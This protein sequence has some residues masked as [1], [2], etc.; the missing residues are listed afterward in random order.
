MSFD[1]NIMQDKINRLKEAYL[2]G[3]FSDA[4]FAAL[5][6]GNG[7][8]QQRI[9]NANLDIDGNGFG[10]YIGIK[11]KAVKF[12]STKNAL[13]LKRNKAILGQSLTSY[14]RYRASRGRQVTKKDLE[15]TGGLRRAIETVIL[16]EKSAVL[17]FSNTDA[18]KIARGQENQITNIRSGL[19]GTT[20][21]FGIKIFKLDTSEKEQVI[22]QGRLLINQIMKR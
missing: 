7:L 14:Q 4:L 1:V 9:F 13:Q 18:V 12:K 10:I 11:S 6:T 20:K 22:E 21:G 15:L 5:N 17:E 3:E 2:K 8:M 16:D 19:K